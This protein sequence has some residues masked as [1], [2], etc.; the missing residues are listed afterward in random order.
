MYGILPK[1]TQ[2]QSTVHWKS[3]A[4]TKLDKAKQNLDKLNKI[5][6]GDEEKGKRLILKP[7]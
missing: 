4:K 6:P 5:I 1:K 7:K 3:K 2:G